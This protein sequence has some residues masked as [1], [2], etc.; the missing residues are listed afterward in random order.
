MVATTDLDHGD[1]RAFL[2]RIR[3]RQGPAPTIGPHPPPAPPR[4]VPEVG[5]R[6]HDGIDR[7]V[8]AALLPAFLDAARRVQAVVHTDGIEAAIAEVVRR[9]EVRHA[10]LSREPAAQATRGALEAAGVDV[11]DH[12]PGLSALADLGVTSCVGAVAAT[13][14]VVVDSDVA[15]GRGA[16]LLPGVHLCVVPRGLVVATPSDVFRRGARPL[17]SNRVVITG[18]SRTGDIEQ[19][20]TL[21][22]HGPTA[23]HLVLVGDR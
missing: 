23:V 4:E 16:S 12:E 9:H 1:R 14:S 15:G 19:I 2:D 17:P 20:I 6:A 10:V 7:N 11:A 5:Y 22:A 8:P 18:P 13:G 21:G 3:S